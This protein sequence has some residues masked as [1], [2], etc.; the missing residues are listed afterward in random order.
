MTLAKSRIAGQAVARSFRKNKSTSLTFKLCTLE[1]PH[2]K[3][4]FP[5]FYTNTQPL[6]PLLTN[7][8]WRAQV[9]TKV[10]ESPSLK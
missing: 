5:K 10:L 3:Y 1:S 7:T 6:F 4:P 9:R 2:T 8:I